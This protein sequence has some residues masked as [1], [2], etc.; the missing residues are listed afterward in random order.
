MLQVQLMLVL[1]CLQCRPSNFKESSAKYPSYKVFSFDSLVVAKVMD[2]SLC[3]D[4]KDLV[5]QLRPIAS[6]L[7]RRPTNGSLLMQM[8]AMPGWASCTPPPRE[9]CQ[10]AIPRCHHARAT[11]MLH[12]K[13]RGEKLT[14]EQQQDV[15]TGLASRD[16]GFITSFISF[17]ATAAPFPS[18][19][20]SVEAIS[21]SPHTW[22]QV[23]AV[24][25]V[26]PAF[27][28]LVQR[29]TTSPAS[30]ATIERVGCSVHSVSYTTISGIG[31]VSKKQAS[32]S[33]VTTCCMQ[34]RTWTCKL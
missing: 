27:D 30:S 10:Q 28:D 11:H 14:M 6:A 32:L 31:W 22:W 19:Y 26:D 17:Q 4:G 3:K 33:F 29:L 5:D 12:P 2:Y 18:S 16:P 1:C 9:S 21:I 24:C 13:Y 8:Y 20:F 23:A 34:P 25:G 15:S 7:D